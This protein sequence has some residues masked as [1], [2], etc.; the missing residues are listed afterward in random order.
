MTKSQYEVD[1]DERVRNIQEHFK[2]LGIPILAQ[3]VR[4]VLSKKEKRKRKTVDKKD[5]DH[6]YD[7]SSD[8]DSQSDTDDDSHDDCDDELIN[9]DN[10]K[11]RCITRATNNYC[12]SLFNHELHCNYLLYF[13]LV[14]Y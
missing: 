9:L 11:V 5:G 6:D 14:P 13:A 2:S 3:E 4:D 10:T 7:P 1:R 8:I 12:V